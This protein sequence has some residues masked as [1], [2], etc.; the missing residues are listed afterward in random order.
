M[1]T[2]LK[3]LRYGVR[4]LAK[5]P[6]FTIVVVAA[7]AIGIG[8]NTAIF[9][10]VNSILLR[11]LPYHDPDR[12][13]MVWMDNHRL[14]LDQDIHSYANYSDYRDKNQSFEPLAVFNGISVNLTGVGEPE[15]V[16]G[17]MASPSFFDVMGVDPLMGRTFSPEE[18]VPGR[19]QVVILGYGFWQRR[20]GG[21]RNILGQE[22]SLSDVKRTV[23]GVMPA[24]FKFPH[25]DAELWVPLAPD[26]NRRN[27]RF[28]FAYQI[29]GRL[30]PGVTLSQAR[31]D[32]GAIATHLVEQFPDLAGYGVNLVPLHEQVVR[33]VRPALLALLATV[34]FVLLIACAN[35]AN[36]LLARAASRE[37]E[38]AIRTALGAGRLRL[39]R[40]LLTESLLIAV[41]GGVVGLLIA[42]WGLRALVAL[43]PEDIP[44]R[45]QIGIDLR[46][47]GFTLLISLLTGLVF[48][49]V[50]ALRASRLDLN[51]S[52]KEG[53]RGASGGVQSRHVRSTLVVFEV[54]LS[55]VLLIGAGL[56]IRSF[57]QLQKVDLGF[58]PDHV[59]RMNIQLSR[60]KY[61]GQQSAAFFRQLIERVEALPGV[62]S[63]G[64][65]TAVFI[66]GLP[67]S[68]NFTIEGRAPVPTAEQIE[69]PI[70]FV[71]PRYFRTMGISLLRGRE[72]TEQD[73]PDS[74]RVV[75]INDTFA[76]R[77]WQG[78]DPIGKRFKFGDSNSNSPWLTIVGVVADMRRTGFDADVRCEAFLPY[79]QRQF[80]GFLTL[81]VRTASDPQ[82]M[83]ATV[84]D[85]VW[86]MDRDQ[87]VSHIG[88]IDQLL[89]GMIAQRRLN[90][91]LFA[92]FAGVALIL[93]AVGIYGV[94]SYSVTQRTHEIGIRMALG[95]GRGEVLKLIV[96]NGMTLV[97]I[98]IGIGLIS[99]AALTR[100]IGTLLY[101]VSATDPVTFAVISAI[102][103][104]VALAACLVPARRATKVDPMIAL[105]YE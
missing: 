79:T 104:G 43:S 72:L 37:R 32:M 103:A 49:L 89:G 39:V 77:F 105:R 76:R 31:Q 22:I 45:G 60:S 56:M 88:T 41:L 87:A 47:L 1:E 26:A 92:L 38:I 102:L 90:T 61:Q 65:I 42:N 68:G 94:I 55:L 71:T 84:R 91:V 40:Q 57:M 78:E 54:A 96:R 14:N 80:I 4:M 58:N 34:A 100:L 11:P 17:T 53:G 20:F 98:G 69:A 46:V 83:A 101:G 23:I 97:G 18:E 21:D 74:P 10:V 5:K 95:A 99:A 67:D 70:D 81:V 52:L 64:A 82:S 27:S 62:E 30:K 93:A 33:R 29:I 75:V 59:L 50:P 9:S 2:L 51:E 35:V 13:V 12:L 86:S 85:V 28:G 48:G 3:D 63:A 73:G 19:D 7:L 66:E 8:A 36:L 44:R 25:K 6:A 24:S 16:I 15:R